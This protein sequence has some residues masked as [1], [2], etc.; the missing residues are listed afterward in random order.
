MNVVV[1]EDVRFS[2]VNGAWYWPTWTLKILA[3]P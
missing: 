3:G 1:F 2:I